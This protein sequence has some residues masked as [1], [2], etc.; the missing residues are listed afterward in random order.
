MIICE[1]HP[2]FGGYFTHV[3]RTFCLGKPEAR[4]L[5]IYDACLAAYR[6]ELGLFR[7]GG[8]ISEAMDAVRDTIEEAASASASNAAMASRRWN[9]RYRHHALRADEGALKAMA[10]SSVRAWCSP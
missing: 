2:K 6:R 10:T 5:D 8:K 9:R 1:M 4:Y 3:E 7:P